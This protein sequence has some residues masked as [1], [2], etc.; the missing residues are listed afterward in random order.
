MQNKSKYFLDNVIEDLNLIGLDLLI[1][2]TYK[3]IKSKSYYTHKQYYLITCDLHC[4]Q[5]VGFYVWYTIQC[6]KLFELW[7]K[8]WL[9][10]DNTDTSKSI[11]YSKSIPP[12]EINDYQY[13][14]ELP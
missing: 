13:R 7:G 6:W 11:E 12:N 2:L 9:S 10:N 8:D 1:L 5:M 4:Y 3:V 14:N